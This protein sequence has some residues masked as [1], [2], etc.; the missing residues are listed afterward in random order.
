M[1]PLPLRSP[2]GGPI[3]RFCGLRDALVAGE[4][5]SP[6]DARTDAGL[7]RKFLPLSRGAEVPWIGAPVAP[8]WGSDGRAS[9]ALFRPRLVSS[10]SFEAGDPP[11]REG[12][13]SHPIVDGLSAGGVE[14]GAALQAHPTPVGDGESR[15]STREG[16]RSEGR[17]TARRVKGPL[18]GRGG[19]TGGV[20]GRSSPERV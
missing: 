17:T 19:P 16:T 18:G 13:R 15:V 1:I 4:S 11:R 3:V 12:D 7:T 9:V 14:F 5:L 6:C 2:R 10:A 8:G 20:G